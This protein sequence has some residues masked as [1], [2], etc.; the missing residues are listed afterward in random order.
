MRAKKRHLDSRATILTILLLAVVSSLTWVGCGPEKKATAPQDCNSITV[1]VTDSGS[2]YH[3]AG[4]RYL[5]HSANALTLC[6]AK[7][8][9]YTPCSVCKPP[10]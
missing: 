1:Y 7:A 2:K 4:C 9:G 5:S 6:D 8:E 10:T 3:V